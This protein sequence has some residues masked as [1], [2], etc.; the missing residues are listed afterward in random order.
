MWVHNFSNALRR[1]PGH[2]L[3]DLVS[4]SYVLYGL[5]LRFAATM[6][7]YGRAILLFELT[8]G[9]YR[10]NETGSMGHTAGQ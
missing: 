10:F 3:V 6:L 7:Q 4:F 1:Q 8:A 5:S 2:A 9:P